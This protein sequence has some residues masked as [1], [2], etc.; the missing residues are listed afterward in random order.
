MGDSVGATDVGSSVGDV[1]GLLVGL[2]VGESVAKQLVVLSG[3]VTKPS[4]H[5]QM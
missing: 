1:V 4:M 5:S 2:S 3:S